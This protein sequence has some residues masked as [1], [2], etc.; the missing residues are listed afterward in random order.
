MKAGLAEFRAFLEKIP[1]ERYRT[2]LRK[3]KY[4]EQ[5][6]PRELLPLE[7]IYRV[8]WVDRQFLSFHEWF[9]RFWNELTGNSEKSDALKRFKAEYFSFAYATSPKKEAWF[10]RGFRARMWRTWTA[11]LTQMDLCYAM[12]AQ[13]EKVEASADL[14]MSGVDLKVQGVS[15]QISKMSAR[16]EAR[17]VQ[18]RI[19][20]VP[21]SIENPEDL[22]RKA[23]NPR[24]RA[25]EKH[26]ARGAAHRKYFK[27]LQN[28]FVVFSEEYV[29]GIATHLGKDQNLVSFL[30]K[31][32]RELE[33]VTRGRPRGSSR[34]RGGHGGF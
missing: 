15:L 21:Y 12:E 3:L 29:K 24:A 31:V 13:G 8:Y 19:I 22:D 14:D 11:I 34:T 17:S 30:G 23:K 1:L 16:K 10:R 9:K 4:V 27:R 20:S 6:L 33:G 2:Q 7:S 5:D 26:A 25:S 18:Q 28:G 32:R